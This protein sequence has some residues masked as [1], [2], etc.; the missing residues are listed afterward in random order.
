MNRNDFRN[1]LIQSGILLL[2]VFLSIAIVANSPA[3][4][5]FGSIFALISG[6]FKGLLFVIAL[7][8]GVI[9]SIAV[10]VGIFLLAV[11]FHSADKAGIMFDQFKTALVALYCKVKGCD[12]S[13]LET[14]SNVSA[15]EEAVSPVPREADPGEAIAPQ[16]SDTGQLKEEISQITDKLDQLDSSLSSAEERLLALQSQVE[17][18]Q[19]SSAEAGDRL[20]H[21]EASSGD[22]ADNVKM[23]SEKIDSIAEEIIELHKKTSVPEVVSGIL[24]YLDTQ[25]DRDTL[26]ERAEEAVSRGLT[27]AQTDDFFK[28][29]LPDKVHKALS[30]HPRLTKDF[31][32]SV[33]KKFE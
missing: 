13:S 20:N 27:Y 28:D 2:V 25:E 8:I 4:G 17:Q 12:N 18:H 30:E 1:P 23:Q 31:I 19:S 32:R 29:V 9:F 10:L 7:S 3:D 22:L 15:V 16:Q 14:V 24:S 5:F 21:I 26:M 11:S 6:L 33:K